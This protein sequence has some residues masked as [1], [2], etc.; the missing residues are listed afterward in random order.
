MFMKYFEISVIFLII[1]II[2]SLVGFRNILRRKL[3]RAYILRKFT[4]I[5]RQNS[6]DC[7]F[8]SY[9]IIKVSDFVY[10][11]PKKNKDI[12]LSDLDSFDYAG[13]IN[14]LSSLNE[15]LSNI[16]LAHFNLKQAKKN[17]QTYLKTNCADILPLLALALIYA[18][19]FDYLKLKKVLTI[20]KQCKADKLQKALILKLEAILAMVD[21]DM[22]SASQNA[23]MSAKIFKKYDLPYEEAESYLLLGEIYRI[24]MVF[25]VSQI[26]YDEAEKIYVLLKSYENMAN[27]KALK[28]ML[29]VAQER[30]DEAKDLFSESEKIFS[31]NKKYVHKA[32]IINQQSLSAILQKKYSKGLKYANNALEIHKKY[33]SI[34]GMAFSYELISLI[35]Y[36]Q[37]KYNEVYISAKLSMKLYLKTKNYSGFQDCGF[38]L[39]QS[40]FCIK[41]Y[42]NSQKICREIID[43]Y[44]KHPTCFHIAGV[45]SLLGMIYVKLKDFNRASALFKKALNME[46]C[47]ERYSAAAADYVNLALISL[48][49][50]HNHDASVHL[51]SALES[52]EKNGDKELCALITKYMKKT[53]KD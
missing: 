12:L 15:S 1:F 44:E 2:A 32:E 35:K 41:D 18:K 37:K 4:E 6:V 40:Y 51:Q 26:M 9:L 45:Y 25:D 46:Q 52:A 33:K 7:I 8:S 29:F 49:R 47:N 22:L 19:E 21:S 14:R 48:R 27:V 5:C 16:V 3:Y 10:S 30:F 20:I 28:G 39:A 38:V 53:L 24:S 11:L 42:E 50:G 13:F 31:E 17:L 43:S 34:R 23:V 36:L